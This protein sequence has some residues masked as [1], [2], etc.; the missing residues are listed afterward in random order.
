MVRVVTVGVGVAALLGGRSSSRDAVSSVWGAC[1]AWVVS[2]A[3]VASLGSGAVAA[4]SSAV[5]GVT[6]SSGAHV[7]STRRTGWATSGSA[8]APPG[9]KSNKP[10][11]RARPNCRIDVK[12]SRKAG[13]YGSAHVQSQVARAVRG[14]AQYR[15]GP[16]DDGCFR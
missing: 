16:R 4:A 5:I 12:R 3:W 13:Y 1:V 10:H 6:T 15:G 8:A 7:A 14:R 2:G 9:V 11:A